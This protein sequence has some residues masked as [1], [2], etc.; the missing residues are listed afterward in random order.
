MQYQFDQLKENERKKNWSAMPKLVERIFFVDRKRSAHMYR[1]I[2]TLHSLLLTREKKSDFFFQKFSKSLKFFS[3]NEKNA[4]SRKLEE[5]EGSN[6]Q[7]RI[8]AQ[9]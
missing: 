3:K 1:L 5:L 7:A 8:R 2:S 6:F 4:I 9:N